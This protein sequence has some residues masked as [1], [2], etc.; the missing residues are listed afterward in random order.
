MIAVLAFTLMILIAAGCYV[1][2]NF[3]ESGSTAQ[4]GLVGLGSGLVGA[5][6]PSVPIWLQSLTNKTRNSQ[7][8]HARLHMICSFG[9]VGLVALLALMFSLS[10]SGCKQVKPDQL[11]QAT[12]DCA[13]VNPQSSAALGAVEDCVAGLVMSNGAACVK[14]LVV[15]MKY[16]DPAI[17]QKVKLRW[18]IDEVACVSAWIAQKNN[19]AVQLAPMDADMGP[20]KARMRARDEAARFLVENQIRI[21]NSY[22]GVP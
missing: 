13:K 5:I 18:T 20:L 9:L 21:R 8:G 11:Y 15:G 17:E 22:V 14:G 7:A 2:A 3:C 19:M 1:G 16:D 12:V 10:T 4:L 6:L